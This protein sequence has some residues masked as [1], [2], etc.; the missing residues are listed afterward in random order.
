MQGHG[1]KH[2]NCVMNLQLIPCLP[3]Q[4]SWV[5]KAGHYWVQQVDWLSFIKELTN[6]WN[7]IN[8]N[9]INVPSIKFLYIIYLNE[10]Y[11]TVQKSH[12]WQ[13]EL[14]FTP[15]AALVY[16]MRYSAALTFS[17][18]DLPR[19]YWFLAEAVISKHGHACEMWR[20]WSNTSILLWLKI[21]YT[22]CSSRQVTCLVNTVLYKSMHSQPSYQEYSTYTVQSKSVGAI[23]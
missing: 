11:S 10:D 17:T 19:K 16:S 5:R 1:H 21:Q 12:N 7:K 15:V 9:N 4:I 23:M 18:C 3:L 20:L 6:V 13:M 22:V 8:W 14:E 2:D